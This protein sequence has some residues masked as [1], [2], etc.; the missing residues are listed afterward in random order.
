MKDIIFL[1]L[2]EVVDIH[3]DQIARYGG[4]DGILDISL[5][6]SAVA[7]PLASFSGGYLHDDIFEMAAAYAFHIC[8]DHPFVDGNKR[9]ALASALVFLDMNGKNII[10]ESGRL[11]DAMMSVATG[12]LSKS[13]FASILRSM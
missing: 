7:M 3:A 9:T 8:Q 1:T 4:S 13:E 6:S 11:Y 2:S 5:L 10:D 12:Q